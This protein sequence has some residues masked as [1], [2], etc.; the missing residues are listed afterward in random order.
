MKKCSYPPGI[1]FRPD[2]V[3]ELSPH[4][5]EEAG[6]PFGSNIEVYQ[7]ARCGSMSILFRGLDDEIYEAYEHAK[8]SA[9]GEHD[10]RLKEIHRNV[11]IDLLLCKNCGDISFA[12]HRTEDTEDNIV[13]EMEK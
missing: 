7:C 3:H 10:N 11:L 9:G 4:R 8:C 13:E 6:F 1:S 2:G 12:W 5:Y